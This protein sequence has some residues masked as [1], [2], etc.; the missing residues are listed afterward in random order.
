MILADKIIELR[1]QF[2]WSQEDLAAKLDVSRQS[3]SKWE[4][5]RSIPDLTK[6]IKMADLFGVSTDYLLKDEIET[7][8]PGGS[9]RDSNLIKISLDK[10]NAYIE[11][12]VAAAKQIAIGVSIIMMAVAPLMILL[13][14]S[15]APTIALDSSDAVAIGLIALLILVAIGVSFFIRSSH[16]GSNFPEIENEEIELAY[17][18]SGIINDKLKNYRQRYTSLI[19]IAVMMFI[20]AA[21]PLIVSAIM[22]ASE[23]IILLMVALMLAIL[24]TGIFLVIPTSARYNG[25]RLLLQE[26]EYS[27]RRKPARRRAEKIGS[28]YWPVVTAIYLGWSFWTMA[29]GITW[30]IWPVSGVAFGAV[31]AL[32]D[33]IAHD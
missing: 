27:P 32:G 25:Y 13:A 1:K 2:G 6:I 16:H 21:T 23:T 3:V 5:A 11:S 10:A 20:L 22:E 7:V 24:A 18:V 28:V 26:G 15:A 12:K 29:W 17:G 8:E 33:L 14:L 4:S 31:V 9:D 19:S 30:I